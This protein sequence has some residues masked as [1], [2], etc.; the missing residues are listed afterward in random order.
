MVPEVIIKKSDKIFLGKDQL[1]NKVNNNPETI[2]MIN[3]IKI[4]YIKILLLY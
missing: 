4:A 2:N 1:S 3:N